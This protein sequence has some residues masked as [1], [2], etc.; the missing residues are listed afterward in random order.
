MTKPGFGTHVLLIGPHGSGKS[1]IGRNLVDQGYVHLS[2]GTLARLA[3]RLHRPSN[4]PNRLFMMLARHVP[5]TPVD[6]ATASMLVEHALSLPKVVI[7]GFPAVASHIDE[8]PD[9]AN[10][11]IVY[12]LTPKQ[13]REAR[14]KQRSLDTPRKWQAGGRSERDAALPSLCRAI[15]ER[16]EMRTISNRADN[17]TPDITRIS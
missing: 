1:T 15:R 5:G 8:L 4:I 10:W 6:S 9:L 7:D 2:V 11:D 14:L 12:V 13:I 3:K 17:L 16:T